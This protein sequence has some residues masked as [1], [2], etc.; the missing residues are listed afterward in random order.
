MSFAT[1]RVFMAGFEGET[2]PSALRELLRNEALAGVIL[3]RRN[4][5]SLPQ[6]SALTSELRE[7]A[8][9]DLLIAVDH[10]GGRVFR[11]PP[12]FTQIP[13][14]ETIGNYAATHAD[15]EKLAFDVGRLMG[16]E[17]AAVGINV[18]F[19]PILDINTNPKNPIIGNRAFSGDTEQIARLGCAMIRGLSE[20]GVIACGKHFPG[21]GDT[22]EDSHRT[23]PVL[24]HTLSRLR[25]MELVPFVRAIEAGVPMLMTAH[26]LYGAIDAS[27]MVT[28]SP[29]AITGLLRE[30]L[31]YEGVVVTDD[32]EMGAVTQMTTPEDAA[33]RSLAAGCDLA[34]ICRD[35]AV[36]RRAL[37]AVAHALDRGA[38][39][40]PNLERAAARIAALHRRLTPFSRVR[41]TE[42]VGCAA[43]RMSVEKLF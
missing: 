27:Q 8:G 32:L 30:E 41:R 28:L 11:M 12:P 23:C 25:F 5:I 10:E 31:G 40:L 29:R 24:P 20:G 43:H 26:I 2:V 39:L 16:A 37:D 19:A 42:V 38:L 6:L 18:N 17:L 33:V 22:P 7:A 21:H 4:I 36:T 14:M 34:L 15:G 9:R 35:L 1:G 13:P 3:F